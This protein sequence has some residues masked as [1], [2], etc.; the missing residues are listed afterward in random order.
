M[1]KDLAGR[2]ALVCGG[3]EGIGLAA[4][5]ALAERGADVTVLAR[6]PGR[7]SEV[8]AGLPRVHESQRHGFVTADAGDTAGLAAQIEHG[9][10]R[11]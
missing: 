2:H 1:H 6:R 3:S 4:A 9:V 11:G 10:D 5:T 7:L 8:A